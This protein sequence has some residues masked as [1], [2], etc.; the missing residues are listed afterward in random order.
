MVGPLCYV[1]WQAGAGCR[2]W[3]SG[4]VETFLVG[5][6]TLARNP[7]LIRAPAAAVGMSSRRLAATAR[8]DGE[9]VRPH[10]GSRRRQ[11]HASGGLELCRRR[12][13][14]HPGRPSRA[15]AIPLRPTPA[16]DPHSGGIV[17]THSRSPPTCWGPCPLGRATCP[18]YLR[19]PVRSHG[20]ARG[21]RTCVP[22]SGNAFRGSARA[23]RPRRWRKAL[24]ELVQ[25]ADDVRPERTGGGDCAGRWWRYCSFLLLAALVSARQLGP[26]LCTGSAGRRK[27][28]RLVAPAA[29]S[30][31]L[32]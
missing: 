11:G 6:R 16:Y 3:G 29:G 18:P 25:S 9:V 26:S 20:N 30:R 17:V 15:S 21:V 5:G 31:G 1:R 10:E 23:R 28:A 14:P 2:K 27:G 22:R 7:R 4:P 32:R 13:S 19:T 24:V 8:V 12:A